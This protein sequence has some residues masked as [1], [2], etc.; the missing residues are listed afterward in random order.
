MLRDLDFAT[1]VP[2]CLL[3]GQG[4]AES[5]EPASSGVTSRYATFRLR[6]LRSIRGRVAPIA[7]YPLPGMSRP[8]MARSQSAPTQGVAPDWYVAP[9]RGFGPP[10]SWVVGPS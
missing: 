8:F 1:L 5:G 6:D 9:L 10:Q 3:G 2:N 4:P 7:I